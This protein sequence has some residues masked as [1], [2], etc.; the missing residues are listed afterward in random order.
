MSLVK[1]FGCLN[2]SIAI[3]LIIEVFITFSGCRAAA[4]SLSHESL[5][6]I[7]SLPSVTFQTHPDNSTASSVILSQVPNPNPNPITPLPPPITPIPPKQPIPAPS[8]QLEIPLP[9]TPPKPPA[10]EPLPGIPGNI[11]VKKFEFEGNTA[12]SNKKLSEVTAQFTNKPI[13]FAEL[14]Q[15]E[16]VVTKL[17]TDAG[18]IN[19][20][21]V[22]P[23]DQKFSPE[24]AIV[25][26]QI[27]EGGI[28]QIKVTGTRRLNPG[29]VRSR[30]ALGVSK[31]LNRYRLL[32][33][34][35]LLQLNPL[36][37]NV[38][39]DL[40]AGSRPE[41]SL[42]EVRIQE[43]DSFHT[44]FFADNGRVP[45]V[46]SFRRGLRISQD[47]LFGIGDSL[48]ARYSNTDGSN[49]LDLNYTVPLN[50]RNG[51]LSLSG[52]FANTNVIE[53]PF[54]RLNIT[55][56][57]NY[58]DMSLR[59]PVIQSPTEELAL[60]LTFSR[61]ES[62]TTLLGENYPISPGSNNNGETRL[63]VLRFFQD[64]TQRSP[65]EVFALRSQ[66]S[67][68]V[69]WLDATV[70]S[71]PPDSRFFSWRG[72]GQYVKLLAPDT[73]LEL[74][75]DLQVST[76]ALVP[77]EQFSLGGLQSVRGYRQ[78]LYLSDNGFF[79]SA[80]VRFPIARVKE[81]EG[82]LQI[83]PFVDFGVAWNS[84]GQRNPSPNNRNTLVGLGLGLQWQMNNR[85]TAR[86]DYGIPL[87]DI[88]SSDRSLQEQGIYFSVN[89][90]PF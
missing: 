65:Q 18:Y 34:L 74:R 69:G 60:G 84:S 56:D 53:P 31:P 50:A 1:Q 20:G 63:S 47:N 70:N 58:I 28:E 6:A 19:S 22:I 44:E 75:S 66:F 36:I 26:V 10:S 85:F 72:Q 90:S 46:G 71:K 88:K 33:A 29:Y 35:Q 61:E 40:S 49:A 11:T 59:Q 57:Y 89:Y 13:T 81:V 17:Y 16:D 12:F 64:Y 51:T 68:G 43:A 79:A 48:S 15:V 78:D 82:V 2:L 80:E 32:E 9:Q 76:R 3:S 52:G 38:S 73:V 86:F 14:L 39:A 21:A 5:N 25:K 7:D 4:D 45:S 77:L 24:G 30:I 37:K 67:L 55:G 62:Q 8:P 42:L 83:V 87:T 23:A 41:E 54:D 27:V